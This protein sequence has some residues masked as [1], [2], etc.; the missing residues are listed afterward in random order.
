LRADAEH[1][2]RTGFTHLKLKLGGPRELERELAGVQALREHHGG[3]VALR[4]DANGALSSSEIEHAWRSLAA[5]GIELFE[6]PGAL[7]ESLL[8][9][10]PLGLDE[11]LQGLDEAAAVALLR[12]RQA[13]YVVLKPMALGGLTHCWRLAEQALALGARPVLSH[14]FDG[15]FAWRAT[16]ALA[17]ALPEGPA[18][19][20]APHAGLEA[21]HLRALPVRQGYLEVWPEPGLG[22]P[23][24]T[25]FS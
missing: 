20:L 24:E 13:R 18:H 4:L 22:A 25:G 6:E 14:A 9:A 21:W 2:L 17:L 12:R 8:G 7:P 23:A 10:L 1:A 3:N 19:G 15:P 16:A 11:S 5:L